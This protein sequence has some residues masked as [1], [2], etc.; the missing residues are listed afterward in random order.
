MGRHAWFN[1]LCAGLIVNFE[2]VTSTAI[3]PVL[4]VAA[5]GLDEMAA[6]RKR[7]VIR[8]ATA[9]GGRERR[10]AGDETR[11]GRLPQDFIDSHR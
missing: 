3:P 10:D 11:F 1:F 5:R 6:G 7:E 2:I 9:C 4:L 8:G